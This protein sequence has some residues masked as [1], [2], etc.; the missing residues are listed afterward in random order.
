MLTRQIQ[1]FILYASVWMDVRLS[2][3]YSTRQVSFCLYVPRSVSVVMLV[4]VNVRLKPSRLFTLLSL[5]AP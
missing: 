4:S 3:L 5:T 2:Q 1:P